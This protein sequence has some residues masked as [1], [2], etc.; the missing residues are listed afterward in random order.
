MRERREKVRAR[1]RNPW[2]ER[3]F[4]GNASLRVRTR[5]SQTRG[6][7]C[8]DVTNARFETCVRDRAR[9]ERRRGCGFRVALTQEEHGRGHGIRVRKQTERREGDIRQVTSYV[10]TIYN[11]CPEDKVH[12][13]GSD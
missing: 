4:R 8:I 3:V 13:Q 2:R 11:T 10:I 5:I 9:G 6:S 7:R 1:E 12:I